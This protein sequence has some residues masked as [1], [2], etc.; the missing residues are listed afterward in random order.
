VHITWLHLS[1]FHIRGGDPYDRDVVLRALIKSVGDFRERGRIPDLIFATG[2]IAFSGK[3]TEYAIATTFFD[4]LLKAARLDKRHLYIIPGNHDVD[5]D[6]GIGLARTF[7]SREESDQYFGPV[8]PKPHLTQ[9]QG[10]FLRWYNEYFH[11][12]REMPL[13]STCGPMEFASIRG[14]RIGILPLNSALFCQDDNDHD[15]LFIG[16]RCLDAALEKLHSFGGELNL[17]LVHHPLDWLSSVERSNIKAELQSHVDFLLRGHLHETEV[18]SVASESGTCLHCAA[19]AAYQTRRWPN[20]AAYA[21]IKDSHVEIFPT[22]YEDQPLAVWT[23]DPSLFPSSPSYEKSFPI[24]R[25]TGKK[26]VSPPQSAHAAPSGAPGRQFWSNIPSRRG[27]AVVGRDDVLNDVLN[28]LG[29]PEEGRVLVLHGP[30]GVGKSEVAREFA[31]RHADRYPGGTF[32]V[33][34]SAGAL[35]VDLA[36]IGRAVLDLHFP[37][38]LSL[39]DQCL[40]TL[41]ALGGAPTLLI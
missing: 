14:D 21:T 41:R 8:I 35:V 27:L 9:K 28:R 10:A 38:D 39:Q 33:D 32:V 4:D 13:D 20:R 34:G 11:G 2:D 18:E 25:L 15:K 19:G 24:P 36:R 6:L 1:D 16:R 3:P 5:R 31:R 37:G 12:I 30:P 29:Q 23:V 40:Q 22:R 7:T 26:A 17:A